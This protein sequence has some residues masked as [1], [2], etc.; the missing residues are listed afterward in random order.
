MWYTFWPMV[1]PYDFKPGFMLIASEKFLFRGDIVSTILDVERNAPVSPR[2]FFI[3]HY[4]LSIFCLRQILGLFTYTLKNV[5]RRGILLAL[6]FL[7][8]SLGLAH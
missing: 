4:E 5:G 3:Y 8:I 7:A 6:T 1:W 2:I